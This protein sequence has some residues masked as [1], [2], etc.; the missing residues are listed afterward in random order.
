MNLI[1]IQRICGALYV[2]QEVYMEY[3]PSE[4]K[5]VWS[6]VKNQVNHFLVKSKRKRGKYELLSYSFIELTT[7]T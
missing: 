3:T 5:N 7:T 1:V 6:S 2:F 4:N